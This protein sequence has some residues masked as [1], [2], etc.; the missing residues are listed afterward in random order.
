MNLQTSKN[1]IGL[2]ALAL[3]LMP[4]VS[5]SASKRRNIVVLLKKKLL[6]LYKS[7]MADAPDWSTQQQSRPN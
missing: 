5:L 6:T 1:A 3:F 2:I 7:A 4:C